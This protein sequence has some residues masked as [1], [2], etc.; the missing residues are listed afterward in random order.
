MPRKLHKTRKYGTFTLLCSSILILVIFSVA[1][2][3]LFDALAIRI[4]NYFWPTIVGLLTFF[5]FVVGGVVKNPPK[6]FSKFLENGFLQIAVVELFLF[7]AGI[8]YFAYLT[9]RPGQVEVKLLSGQELPKIKVLVTSS[10]TPGRLDT[11]LVPDILP[12]QKPGVLTFRIVDSSYETDSRTIELGSGEAKVVTL[13][14]RKISGTIIVDSDPRGAGIWIDDS[15]TSRKTPDTLR[16]LKKAEVRLKLEKE[17]FAPYQR[18][19]NLASIPQQNLGV[20]PLRKLFNVTFLC[21]IEDIRWEL[22]GRVYVGS[23][24]IR[25]PGGNHTLSVMKPDGSRTPKSF[26]VDRDRTV[27]IQ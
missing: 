20:V 27:P 10:E 16:G 24:E 12:N 11:L 14:D 4:Q 26:Y 17:G 8:S 19:V 6:S 5:G 9:S 2:P 3:E 25:L 7:S 18:T 21:P 1:K 23:Q 13:T 15:F 22:G